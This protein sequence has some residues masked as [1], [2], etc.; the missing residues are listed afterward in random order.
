MSRIESSARN[1]AGNGHSSGWSPSGWEVNVGNLGSSVLRR[2]GHAP[3]SEETG[4][5]HDGEQSPEGMSTQDPDSPSSVPP[6]PS[7]RRS[8]RFGLSVIIA[9]LVLGGLILLVGLFTDP[10]DAH[11]GWTRSL[12]VAASA[13][14]LVD[15]GL[16]LIMGRRRARV[17]EP[18]P[19]AEPT[20][21]HT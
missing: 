1:G 17:P 11:P 20:E 10:A 4:E 21:S 7:R 3:A 2:P 13:A 19:A 5:T 8:N 15:A 9:N 18:A 6:P 12:L 16:F 14:L